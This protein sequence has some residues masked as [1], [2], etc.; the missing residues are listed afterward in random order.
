MCPGEAR[1]GCRDLCPLRVSPAL[2]IAGVECG[3]FSVPQIY[4][5]IE[6]LGSEGPHNY[7]TSVAVALCPA[8]VRGTR[9]A[10]TEIPRR[11]VSRPKGLCLFLGGAGPWIPPRNVSVSRGVC[12]RVQWFPWPDRY[13]II[14]IRPNRL[15]CNNILCTCRYTFLNI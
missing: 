5:E 2:L 8:W 15:K 11:C 14:N 1:P 12:A 10:D 9:D 3:A 4:S 13:V 7:S 6:S